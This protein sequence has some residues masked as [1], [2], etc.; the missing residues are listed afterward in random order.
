M[1]IAAACFL[2]IEPRL[3]LFDRGAG[4]DQRI[5]PHDVIDVDADRREQVDALEVRRSAG[6][7]DVERVAVDD[8]RSLAEAELAQLLAQLPGLALGDVEIVEHEQLPRLSLGRQ[9]HLE[10]QRPNLLVERR[11]EVANARSVGLAAADEDRCP[12]IAVTSGAAAL[13]PTE[14]LAGAIDLGTLAGCAGGAAA[15]LELPRDDAVKD[16]GTRLDSEDVVVELDVPASLGVEG[17]DLDLHL[18]FPCSRQ[19]RAWPRP[20]ELPQWLPRQP[21]FRLPPRSRCRA[22][23]RLPARRRSRRLPRRSATPGSHGPRHRRPGPRP[24]PRPHRP[25]APRPGPPDMARRRAAAA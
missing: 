4:Q 8:Q 17:L 14:L 6:E 25:S 5:V 24:E 20:T 11:V 9:G 23:R 13:L 7:T 15:L 22:R 1:S 16:V 2:A 19:S 18:S 21:R 10:A 3:Q 12:A